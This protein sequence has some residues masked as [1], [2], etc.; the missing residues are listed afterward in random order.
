MSETT[1]PT[2][3]GKRRAE[4]VQYPEVRFMTYP[5]LAEWRRPKPNSGRECKICGGKPAGLQFIQVSIFRGEDEAVAA[6][7]ECAR[8]RKSEVLAAVRS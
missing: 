6:C 4:T 5:R 2:H 8:R 3:D 1:Q 7:Q